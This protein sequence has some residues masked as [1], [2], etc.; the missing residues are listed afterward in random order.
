MPVNEG[1]TELARPIFVIGSLRSGASLLTCALGQHPHLDPVLAMDWLEPLTI[2]LQRSF[3][4]GVQPRA[5]SQLDVAGV[6]IEEFF[7]HFGEAIN[8]LVLGGPEV[9]ASYL[10]DD[11]QDEE[12]PVLR[13]PLR[14]GRWVDGTPAHSFNVFALHRLF[15]AAQFIHVLRDPQGVIESL[16]NPENRRFYRS[17]HLEY[18]EEAAAQHWLQAVRACVD[19]ERALGSGTVL[20]LRHD[21]LVAAPEAAL[22]RCLAFLGEPFDPA[23]LRPY[24]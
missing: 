7:A 22:R 18:T 19:A 21:E 1:T 11:G 24:R 10:D 8:R 5:T 12:L 9:N 16:T 20:R 23:C 4:A 14:A 6:E 17:Q 13:R 2:G 15:P 3:A